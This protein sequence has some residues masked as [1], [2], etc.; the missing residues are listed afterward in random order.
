MVSFTL[1][2]LYHLGK[3]PPYSLDKKLSVGGGE[4]KKSNPGPLRELNPGRAAR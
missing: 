1:R 2:P 3:G 4:E